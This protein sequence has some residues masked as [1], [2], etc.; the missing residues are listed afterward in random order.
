MIVA[1]KKGVDDIRGREASSL[2]ISKVALLEGFAPIIR[3]LHFP[4]SLR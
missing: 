1:R 4:Q 2:S 3:H